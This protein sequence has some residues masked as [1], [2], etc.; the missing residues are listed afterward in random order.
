[1]TGNRRLGFLVTLNAALLVALALSVLTDA[2]PVTAQTQTGSPNRYVMIAAEQG[3]I[4]RTGARLSTILVLDLDQSLLVALNYNRPRR[5]LEVVAVRNL[6]R[7]VEASL[8]APSN[9]TY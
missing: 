5:P 3:E 7:D 4:R 2:Q 1:M 9:R 8:P 6:A